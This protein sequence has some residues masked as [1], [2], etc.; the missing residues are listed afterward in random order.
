MTASK[1]GILLGKI[2]RL[3]AETLTKQE[4]QRSAVSRRNNLGHLY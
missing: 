3:D 2:P 1:T 4:L